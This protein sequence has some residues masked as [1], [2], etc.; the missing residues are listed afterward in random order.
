S[1]AS[2]LPHSHFF[3]GGG[4][5]L[6]VVRWRMLTAGFR[7]Q[8]ERRRRAWNPGGRQP[9]PRE[10]RQRLS[11]SAY[12]R[13]Q[14]DALRGER[15]IQV[16]DSFVDFGRALVADCD[17]IDSRVPERERHRLPTVLAI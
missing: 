7:A 9:P 14:P 16:L 6:S 17:A 8:T 1:R 12:G 10:R 4:E 5:P 3:N 11:D 15:Q 2:N 13:S